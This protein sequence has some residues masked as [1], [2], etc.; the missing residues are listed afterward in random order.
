MSDEITR[1][2]LPGLLKAYSALKEFGNE[3]S[4]NFNGNKLMQEL[5]EQAKAA[6]PHP[7]AA[8]SAPDAHER[9]LSDPNN[10]PFPGG[11]SGIPMPAL[12][13][14]P[15]EREAFAREV[16]YTVIKHKDLVGLP[17]ELLVELRLVL[18]RLGEFTPERNY[19]V[20][21][22]DW[23]EY[24]PV[25]RMI[26]DRVTGAAWQRA[27]SAPVVPEGWRLVPEDATHAMRDAGNDALDRIAADATRGL[28]DKAFYAFCAMLAAAPQPARKPLELSITPEWVRKAAEAEQGHVIAAGVPDPTARQEQAAENEVRRLREALEKAKGVLDEVWE[29]SY[30]HSAASAMNARDMAEEIDAVLS[31]SA[32]G[33]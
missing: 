19:V 8:Q 31:A 33:K 26:E 23:P 29:F 16:R 11:L 9:W 12:Q 3:V 18:D 30:E 10:E 5:I 27:Q 20:V 13:S 32:E 2:D 4:L 7:I 17:R 15:D 14:A 25:W 1:A 21:E 28:A 22:D 6:N 24:E